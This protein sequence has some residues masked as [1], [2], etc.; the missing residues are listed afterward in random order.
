WAD[1][2]TARGR[3]GHVRMGPRA[4]LQ[5]LQ[6]RL[7]LT[8]PPGE[9]AVRIAQYLRLIERHLATP[10]G[11][12][13]FWPARSLALDPGASASQLLRWREAAVG[14]GRR[15]GARPAERHE[16][17]PRRLEALR[18]VESLVVVGMPGTQGTDG[19]AATLSP[20]TAD[21]LAELIAL[22]EEQNREG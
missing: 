5:L 1:A 22:L 19:R 14:A 20:S 8:R 4:L 13:S 16:G 7:G 2:S 3:A 6:T 10:A 11:A 9:G 18:A 21:D 17:L 15:M 12:R